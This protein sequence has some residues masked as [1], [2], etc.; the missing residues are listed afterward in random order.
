VRVPAL[1]REQGMPRVLFRQQKR[2]RQRRP[3]VL[4]V[5]QRWLCMVACIR[6]HSTTKPGCLTRVRAHVYVFIRS[7]VGIDEPLFNSFGCVDGTKIDSSTQR[8]PGTQSH[9]SAVICTCVGHRVWRSQHVRVLCGNVGAASRLI[10]PV[11]FRNQTPFVSEGDQPLFV[12]FPRLAFVS[13]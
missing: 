7:K 3:V 11:R 9:R 4:Q 1:R 2:Q 12:S 8:A 10:L 5:R 6:A 13:A